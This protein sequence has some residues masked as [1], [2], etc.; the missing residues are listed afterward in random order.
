MNLFF[1]VK[2]FFGQTL[3]RGLK[4]YEVIWVNWLGKDTHKLILIDNR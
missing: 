1:S 4:W 2:Q 3:D